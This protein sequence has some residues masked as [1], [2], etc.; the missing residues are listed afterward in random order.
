MI[1]RERTDNWIVALDVGTTKI[2]CVIAQENNGRLEVLGL[3]HHPTAGLSGSGVVDMDETVH[4]I[5]NA[6]RK[7][8][9]CIPG[10]K[11]HQATVGIG[12]GYVQ[13]FNTVGS[14]ALPGHGRGVT[15]DDVNRAIRIAARKSVPKDMTVIHNIPRRFRLDN[16]ANIQDPVGMAG[17]LLEV[18]VHIVTAQESI[19]RNI[20]R[21][22]TKAGLK[23]ER[24]V[25]QP[26]AAASSVLTEE[27]RDAGV[28]V[29]DIGGSTT[30]IVV[31]YEGCIQ[32]TEILGVGGEHIT[33][34]INHYFQTP[35]ENAERLKIY[36]GSA[37][38]ESISDKDL[39]KVVRFKNRR[40]VMAKRRRLCWVIE[41]RV[42]Q[43]LREVSRT[44][45]SRDLLR[46]LYGGVVLTGGTSL[47]D[48]LV[49]RA[50]KI[51]HRE[52]HIGYPNGVIG[53]ADLNSPIYASGIG[54]LHY[55]YQERLLENMYRESA[56][57][58][59]VVRGLE[60]LRETF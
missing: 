8:F 5:E 33:R 10:V 49:E 26:I 23:V 4:S 22:I 37:L 27:E 28:A 29:I 11:V 32:H 2:C 20:T 31:Y 30:S 39:I 41:A 45:Q 44:L 7:A 35:I 14:I 59:V 18:D 34:D 60:W 38:T 21:C 46:H 13:C 47:L 12:G 52:A 48:G 57:K 19:I 56:V 1:R 25:L 55:S 16:N 40:T 54:L 50:E 42:D 53:L 9:A 3:G 24:F 36:S 6:I 51:M 43:I 17:S 58:R 15:R